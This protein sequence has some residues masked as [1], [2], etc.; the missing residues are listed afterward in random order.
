MFIAGI[1]LPKHALSNLALI[2]VK[3]SKKLSP[4]RRRSLF[5]KIISVAKAVIILRYDPQ[6][7]DKVNLT[8]LTLKGFIDILISFQD[9][10]LQVHE[11]YIDAIRS[12]HAFNIISKYLPKGSKLIYEA[13]AD[14]KYIAVSAASIIAKHLRDKHVEIM[15]ERY[16][17]FGSGYPSDPKTIEWLKK[18]LKNDGIDE[19]PPIVRKSWKTIKR[20]AIKGAIIK[21]GKTILELD[22]GTS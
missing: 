10:Q 12:R 5:P 7:I 15:R 21:T 4:S 9:L 19:L 6:T 13:K 20:F 16:G 2:G 17:N 11:V 14:E 18:R 1:T 22:Q 3:D 8:S